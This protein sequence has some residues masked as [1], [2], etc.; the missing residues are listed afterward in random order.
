MSETDPFAENEAAPDGER[1]PASLAA[2]YERQSGEMMV[3]GGTFFG[4]FFLLGGIMSGTVAFLLLACAMLGSAFYFF[5]MIRTERAQLRV[6]A[7]GFY[8]DGMG[9][10]PWSG[11]RS[12]RMYDR[13]VR[14]IR[15]AHLELT[16]AGPADEIVLKDDARP[17]AIRSMMTTVWSLKRNADGEKSRLVVI[18]LEPLSATPEDII[19]AMRRYMGT[20]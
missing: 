17:D 12:V 6:E 3:Y 1:A 2:T 18:G 5:P 16:L 13:A 19:A 7:R 10:L 4:L 8:L 11:I 20:S 15:N 9:W 14:T